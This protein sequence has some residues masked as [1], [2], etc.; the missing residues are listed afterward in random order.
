MDTDLW[1]WK[2][3]EQL[4]IHNFFKAWAGKRQDICVLTRLHFKPFLHREHRGP[5]HVLYIYL[6]P[7][8][9]S[10]HQ[11]SQLPIRIA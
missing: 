8:N 11:R 1:L 9:T 2:E 6:L 5:R 3:K 4:L 10:Y 7:C